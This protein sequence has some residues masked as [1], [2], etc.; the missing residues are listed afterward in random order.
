MDAGRCGFKTLKV[1]TCEWEENRTG[2]AAT[3]KNANAVSQVSVAEGHFT[4][5]RSFT[6][7]RRSAFY[8][9]LFFFCFAPDCSF[10]FGCRSCRRKW[11]IVPFRCNS[12]ANVCDTERSRPGVTK[13]RR[14]HKR[15]F[16]SI[17]TDVRDKPQRRLSAIA[18]G[19]AVGASA[20][21]DNG[22]AGMARCSSTKQQCT[23]RFCETFGAQRPTN[24]LQRSC[25]QRRLRA[26]GDTPQ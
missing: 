1:Y 23:E 12:A 11:E 20:A 18:E 8:L 6:S 2:A 17:C 3:P 13:R 9:F 15:A 19:S 25:K 22:S 5:A 10:L 14:K 26:E 24:S 4:S 7:H 21:A 16:D